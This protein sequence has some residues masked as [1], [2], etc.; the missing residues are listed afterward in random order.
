MSDS[1]CDPQLSDRSPVT[2]PSRNDWFDI[3]LLIKAT[4]RLNRSKV[5][6]LS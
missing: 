6:I 2:L 3:S 1:A 4:V 5:T